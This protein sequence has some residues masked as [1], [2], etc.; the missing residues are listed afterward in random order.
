VIEGNL[1][2]P[3]NNCF[4]ALPMYWPVRSFNMIVFCESVIVGLD[5]NALESSLF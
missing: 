2:L 5:Q 1:S 3:K 4:L